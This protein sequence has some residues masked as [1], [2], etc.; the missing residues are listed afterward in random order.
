MTAPSTTLEQTTRQTGRFRFWLVFGLAIIML[1]PM[2]DRVAL[3]LLLTDDGFQRATAILGDPIRQG[4]LVTAYVIPYGIFNV[5]LGPAIDR[6]GGRRMLGLMTAGWVLASAGLGIVMGFFAA[7]LLRAVRGVADAPLYPLMSRFVKLWFPPRERGS[8]NAI[9]LSASP[10]G[11]TVAVPA[12][13]LLL[14]ALGYQGVLLTVAAI[15]GVVCLPLL[16]WLISDRPEQSRWVGPAERVLITSGEAPQVATGGRF[17][18]ARLF[19]ANYHYWLLVVNHIAYMS[20]YWGL[21]AWYPTY[22][23]EV[24]GFTAE[25]MEIHYTAFWLGG[26]VSTV[27]AG[28]ITDRLG[29][30][31]PSL[32]VSMAGSTLTI[33]LATLVSDG[34]LAAWLIVGCG[35]LFNASSPPFYALMQRIIPAQVM[36]AGAGLDNGLTNL[37][38]AS[39]P[40]VMGYLIA[41]GGGYTAGLLFLAAVA[42][43]GAFASAVLAWERY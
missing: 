32:L 20:I 31:G 43:A 2:M 41:L 23:R 15:T 28:L 35:V 22:L 30:R 10:I 38:A 37:V 25:S 7:A 1:F 11:H 21:I 19:L 42:G 8:A 6:L 3:S 18:G 24:R 17:A 26:I 12:V 36:G 13:A 40:A 9:W 33:V 5:L 29:L 39:V 4:W 27:A 34:V 14:A 16:W